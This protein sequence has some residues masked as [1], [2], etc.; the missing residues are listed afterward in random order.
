MAAE[1]RTRT[2]P[3]CSTVRS[4]LLTALGNLTAMGDQQSP[5][6]PSTVPSF[7][8]F[9]D[10]LQQHRLECAF[11]ACHHSF[12][13]THSAETLASHWLQS[14]I[15][16]GGRNTGGH[17]SH[18]GG[19]ACQA[20]W[21]AANQGF[22][23]L[24]RATQP[25][26]NSIQGHTSEQ[27]DHQ[28]TWRSTA[29]DIA[30]SDLS[31]AFE[32][33][34]NPLLSS[35]ELISL[36]RSMWCAVEE[37]FSLDFDVNSENRP[38]SQQP[39][40]LLSREKKRAFPTPALLSAMPVSS[41]PTSLSPV[42]PSS[43]VTLITLAMGELG[44]AQA[45]WLLSTALPLGWRVLVGTGAWAGRSTLAFKAR[46][47]RK[48]VGYV[49]TPL[50]VFAD[51]RDMLAQLP[52]AAVVDA[53]PHTGADFVWAADPACYPL[54]GFP[55]NL[56][57]G[58]ALCDR[59]FPKSSGGSGRSRSS[60]SGSGGSGGGRGGKLRESWR[61]GSESAAQKS[62]VGGAGTVNRW[63]NSGGWV[64][65]RGA[66]L[67]VLRRLDAPLADGEES[68]RQSGGGVGSQRGVPAWAGVETR[69]APQM[70]AEEGNEPRQL[71]R[72]SA[73]SVGLCADAGTDQ[74]YANTQFLRH[75]A[76]RRLLG[77]A[78]VG[79]S[80]GESTVGLRS[81]L[82]GHG[83]TGGTQG[84]GRGASTG[85]PSSDFGP[86]APAPSATQVIDSDALFFACAA[87]IGPV[88]DQQL[89]LTL[90]RRSSGEVFGETSRRLSA[91]MTSKPHEK[92]QQ[93]GA[94]ALTRSAHATRRQHAP[95]R[96]QMPRHAFCKQTWGGP[97]T[98]SVSDV[99]VADDVSNG[100]HAYNASLVATDAASFVGAGCP[101]LLH[102]NGRAKESALKPTVAALL[103][104]DVQVAARRRGERLH[105][106]RGSVMAVDLDV[107][108]DEI[109]DRSGGATGGSRAATASAGGDSDL[110][111]SRAALTRVHVLLEII[112]GQDHCK[113]SPTACIWCNATIMSIH[114]MKMTRT[115]GTFS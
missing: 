31:F 61:D 37:E 101:A 74:W 1:C 110:Q 96:A 78:D 21:H 67:S 28:Q 48:L 77:R 86:L 16:C 13:G 99:S 109:T 54:G 41:M 27:Q 84:V 12:P 68:G 25:Q 100:A 33:I 112:R 107:A 7:A 105:R 91:S 69:A 9:S 5:K 50:V 40:A 39:L 2:R 51:G 10:I 44:V 70:E 49:E 63:I 55:Y 32:P 11:H 82:G 65:T 15:E 92:V 114:R 30:D 45:C 14:A 104:R 97:S 56:G 38:P 73:Q 88:E 53:F 98:P 47:L 76:E 93:R 43:S 34:R 18:Y 59:L 71:R 58:G 36:L 81:Q 6:G 106:S 79:L 95:R 72:R 52:P 90:V 4:R 22:R 108:P 66:A 85:A 26:L 57:L 80:H 111:R 42:S 75:R 46:V 89:V 17:E 29:R 102:F 64:A 87:A 94:D 19:Q 60:S 83:T 20:V 115:A 24:S 23:K 103:L 113:K 62:K 35:A 8:R 3:S